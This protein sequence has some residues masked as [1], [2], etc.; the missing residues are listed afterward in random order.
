M[1]EENK[2]IINKILLIG[3]KF[4][5]EMHLWNPKVK[6]YPACCPFTRHI[7]RINDFIKDGKL[8]HILK[9]RLD[10]ACFQHDSAYAEYKDRLNR[11]Q[12]DVVLKNKALKI[13]MDPRINEYQRGLASMV[14]KCFDERTKGSGLKY[15]K[16]LNENKQLANE[17]HK[18]IIKN[19]KRR[20]EYFSFKAN[21]WGVEL[22]DMSL[23]SK[24]NKGIKCLLCVIDLF[25]RNSG[26]IPLKTKKRD[27]I[28]ER[29][30]SILKNSDRKP[31]KIWMD[32]GKEFYNN[33]FKS[34]L[35]N[36]NIEIYS[37][38]NE[39]KSV[40]VERFIKTLKNKI[41]KHMTVVGKNVY[42]NDLDDIVKNYNNTI[43]SSIKIKPNDV[44]DNNLTEYIEE[45]NKKILNL[46]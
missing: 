30:K 27:S 15:D 24:F 21:I 2:D 18:P 32:H 31:N 37:T 8:S 23:I 26:V 16:K 9:N 38:F 35:K 41:Y 43:H 25:S 42:F 17:L 12:S 5:P 3:D 34:F 33:K 6:K 11:R 13:A 19:F 45:F 36:N 40:V 46:K 7:Q 39:G 14:Y 29:F 22:A 44:N 1:N 4:M 28:V 20:K 10:A